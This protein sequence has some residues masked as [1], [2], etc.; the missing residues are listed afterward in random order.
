VWQNFIVHG[1]TGQ[2]KLYSATTEES[3]TYSVDGSLTT[4]RPY[5]TVY[6]YDDQ[7]RMTSAFGTRPER[8]WRC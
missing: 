1:P 2:A 7:G 5:T 6:A 8:R 3:A 4:T